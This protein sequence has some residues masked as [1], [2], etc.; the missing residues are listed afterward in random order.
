MSLPRIHAGRR[1]RWLALLVIN[2]AAQASCGFLIAYLLRDALKISRSGSPPWGLALAITG[3]GA[4]VL[5]L[6]TREASDAERLG[7]DYVMRVRLRIFDRIASSPARATGRRRWG[8]TMTRLISD[9]GS[10]RNWVSLGI[11]RAIVATMTIVGLLLSLFYFS[12]MSAWAALGA[13]GVCG[14]VAAALVPTLRSRIRDARRRRGRLA[15][16]LG[17]KI[18][19]AQTVT[20]L[21]RLRRERRRIRRQS[22]KLR[23]SLVR[24]VRLS[25]VLRGLPHFARPAAISGITIA[26]ALTAQSASETVVAV[27]LVGMIASAMGDL[28]RA[29]DYRLSFEEGRRRIDEILDV[30]RI[31]ESKAAVAL[32]GKGPL[33]VVF[34]SVRVTDAVGP[35]DLEIRAGERVLLV[36]PAGS[37]KSTL[38]SLPAR[39]LEADEG[40]IRLDGHPLGEISLDALHEAVQLV[41]PVLPLLRGTVADNIG[42]GATALSVENDEWIEDV[43]EACGLALDPLLPEGLETRL[44]EQGANMPQGLRTRIALARAA[45]MQPRLL[46]IDDPT[47]IGD[48]DAARALDRILTR[49][50]ATAMI[51]GVEQGPRPEVDRVIELTRAGVPADPNGRGPVALGQLELARIPASQTH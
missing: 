32:P 36:G 25:A 37:G 7:Q 3:L 51:V 30:P 44:E 8:V 40:E 24:R 5:A 17:E 27:L 6:R 2:G 31:V 15:N 35:L 12:P 45:A 48:G 41:S 16:N 1:K 9:L 14:I 42:Y 47:A 19:A 4:L 22:M 20:Q 34:D 38:I 46:L 26:A 23:E 29:W 43:I 10:L 49:T 11:A 28:A 21:G 50:G 18:F 39:L 33:S 13:L